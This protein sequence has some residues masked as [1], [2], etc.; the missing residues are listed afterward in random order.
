MLQGSLVRRTAADESSERCDR[1]GVGI[2]Q[3]TP[4]AHVLRR[5][6][7]YGCVAY[8]GYLPIDLVQRVASDSPSSF[9]FAFEILFWMLCFVEYHFEFQH[10]YI[11][12][13][14]LETRFGQLEMVLCS[15]YSIFL[16]TLFADVC[17][18]VFSSPCVGA[19]LN[20]E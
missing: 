7:I 8:G 18:T 17:G 6:R 9:R 19:R 4:P 10:Y 5:P 14:A 16:L 12:N 2:R 1:R 11:V 20:S 13:L 3:R 15:R